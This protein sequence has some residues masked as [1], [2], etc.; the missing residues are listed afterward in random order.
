MF[1]QATLNY[2]HTLTTEHL[3]CL[4]ASTEDRS[5]TQSSFNK[6][7]QLG[8][9]SRSRPLASSARPTVKLSVP[10]EMRASVASY[11]N[12]FNKYL[13]DTATHEQGKFDPWGLVDR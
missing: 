6:G 1:G 11:R 3:P 4:P 7:T 8:G 13:R 2:Q 12:R 5:S 9:P 10:E